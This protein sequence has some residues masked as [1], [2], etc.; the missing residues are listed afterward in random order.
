MNNIHAT[1]T[2][3]VQPAAPSPLDL[4]VSNAF[5]DSLAS[6]PDS[7]RSHAPDETTLSPSAANSMTVLLLDPACILVPDRKT[8]MPNRTPDEFKDD[9]FEELCHSMSRGPLR[10]NSEPIAVHPIDQ[11]RSASGSQKVYV[12]ISGERRLRACIDCGLQVRA[13]VYEKP[14]AGT[15]D[16]DSVIENACR[17]D[18][19]PYDFGRRI[20][21]LI[22]AENGPSMAALAGMVGR[23]KSTLSRAALLAQLPQEVVDAF[24]STGDIRY[25]DGGPLTDAL[26]LANEAVLAEAHSI[27]SSGE[28]IKCSEVVKRLVDAAKGAQAHQ[29]GGDKEGGAPCN[30][31]VSTAMTCGERNVGELGLDRKGQVQITLSVALNEDQK[32]ALAK[33]IE[34]FIRRRVLRLPADKPAA[35]PADN[36]VVVAKSDVPTMPQDVAH[37]EGDV[38]KEGGVA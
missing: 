2:S 20:H 28:K 1:P 29:Q 36:V 12:L 17:K 11:A 23:D 14:R 31:P 3:A 18:L 34:V 15:F 33:Q 10:S 19:S 13:M 35:R 24:A 5:D 8:G 21:Y 25:A 27:K 37:D 26:L 16:M 7:P 38:K 22:N 6:Q 32:T 30:T 9:A 4:D